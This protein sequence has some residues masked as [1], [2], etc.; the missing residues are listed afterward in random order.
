M[1]QKEAGEDEEDADCVIYHS[2][3][4]YDHLFDYPRGWSLNYTGRRKGGKK[5][6]YPA[7]TPEAARIR[8]RLIDEE[9]LDEKI[10]AAARAKVEARVGKAL[11]K[12]QAKAA[13]ATAA[14]KRISTTGPLYKA[15]KAEVKLALEKHGFTAVR[16][17][18]DNPEAWHEMLVD[19]VMWSRRLHF[20]HRAVMLLGSVRWDG[21]H[22]TPDYMPDWSPE[23]TQYRDHIQQPP[24]DYE[25]RSLLDT[26]WFQEKRFLWHALDTL[27]A[28]MRASFVSGWMLEEI[29][30]EAS[31]EEWAYFREKEHD[32]TQL[33]PFVDDTA[34]CV[35]V[36]DNRYAGGSTDDDDDE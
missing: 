31:E 30:K 2:M 12:T 19:I 6:Y 27:V 15:F 8:L 24:P 18:S 20:R 22:D 21:K 28:S 17:K 14:K 34:V 10:F 32:E 36:T 25:V 11:P 13:A 26:M 7:I 4:D 23:S 1:D 16:G 9:L 3:V 35:N 29:M 5:G 33:S